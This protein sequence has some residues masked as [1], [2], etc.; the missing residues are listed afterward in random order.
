[1]SF[2]RPE[3]VRLLRRWREVL[4]A[5]AAAAF[6][7]WLASRGGPLMAAL[8]GA[9]VAASLALAVI[10]WRRQRF[11]LDVTAPGVVHVDEGRVTY[12]GPVMGGSLSLAELAEIEVIDVAGGRRCWRLMQS[13]GQTL[14]VPLA[15]AGADGLYD[16]FAALPGM[17]ARR[18]L[19]ALDGPADRARLIWRHPAG[20]EGTVCALRG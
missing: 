12:L 11:R 5:L 20:R 1:M 4:A 15:S 16:Q 7:A 2:L 8:G 6:G 14:L 9:V 19:S 13:D 17:D 3:V 10:A 18:L